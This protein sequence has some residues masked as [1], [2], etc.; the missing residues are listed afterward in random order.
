MRDLDVPAYSASVPTTT[1]STESQARAGATLYFSG[2]SE[3]QTIDYTR[4]AG[5]YVPV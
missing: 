4:P 3:N 1:L 2:S 5:Q